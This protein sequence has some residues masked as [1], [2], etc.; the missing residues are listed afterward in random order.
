MHSATTIRK[1]KL[2]LCVRHDASACCKTENV[3]DYYQTD[4]HWY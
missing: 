1:K 4:R 3:D 2:E